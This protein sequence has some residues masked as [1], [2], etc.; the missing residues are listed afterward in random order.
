MRCMTLCIIL[1]DVLYAIATDPGTIAMVQ[2][3]GFSMKIRGFTMGLSP[4]MMSLVL[5][6]NVSQFS[7]CLSPLANWEARSQLFFGARQ[8]ANFSLVQW[9][10]VVG[11][12]SP[13]PTPL[14]T[15]VTDGLGYGTC[16]NTSFHHSVSSPSKLRNSV[17]GILNGNCWKIQYDKADKVYQYNPSNWLTVTIQ[18]C[19]D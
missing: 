4:T 10:R 5:Q 14:A 6:D 19:H 15:S 8:E 1:W 12:S 11:G 2:G 9:R 17:L 3:F 18:S 7:Y 13:P 16:Q